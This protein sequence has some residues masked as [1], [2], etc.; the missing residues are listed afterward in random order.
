MRAAPNFKGLLRGNHQ[1][2]KDSLLLNE[3]TA[4][5]KKVFSDGRLEEKAQQLADWQ[6]AC[7]DVI[8]H[9][10][11]LSSSISWICGCRT[12]MQ[13]LSST[14]ELGTNTPHIGVSSQLSV[15][16]RSGSD[17]LPNLV[18][19]IS[20]WTHDVTSKLSAPSP[21]MLIQ[22]S[23]SGNRNH[24]TAWTKWLGR[25]YSWPPFV[26]IFERVGFQ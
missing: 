2:S 25:C 9:A 3:Q 19:W 13:F 17:D 24:F 10:L 4:C 16:K 6:I 5:L 8:Y 11:C 26:E 22:F 18:R 21:K 15:R 12:V 1:T 14:G 23:H 7:W 20:S